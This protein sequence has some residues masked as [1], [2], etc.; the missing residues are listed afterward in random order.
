MT[1][2]FT[3]LPVYLFGNLHCLGMCGP[4][5]AMIGQHRYRLFYFLG[6]TLAFTVAGGI[7][8]AIGAVLDITLKEYQIPFL[9]SFLFGSI[10]FVIGITTLTGWRSP[11]VKWI[12]PLMAK[13]TR[14]LATLMLKDRAWTT[15]VF[16]LLTIALPCGQT[17]LVFS[18]CA[19]SGSMLVGT[20]NGFA[21]ALLTSPSLFFAMHAHQFLSK[22]KNHYHTVLGISALIIGTLALLR[23]F[24]DIG[25]IP[26]FILNPNASPYYH[27]VL[28]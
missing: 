16:G 26:H 1:L 18:A 7:A 20:G 6:R 23:G 8:G 22:A 24:A 9:T 2:F 15:F 4:L 17:V 27:L 25:A 5:V 13:A 19:L 12:A 3:L 14:P 11:G 10:I 28:F 21:F